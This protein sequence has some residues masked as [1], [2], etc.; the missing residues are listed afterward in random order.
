[1]GIIK[2]EHY[3][4]YSKLDL[5]FSMYFIAE[6]EYVRAKVL[7][8]MCHSFLPPKYMKT[9]SNPQKI[10]VKRTPKYRKEKTKS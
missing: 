7:Q 3:G 8:F 1:M 4:F 6:Y 2:F 9:K 10:L 5:L